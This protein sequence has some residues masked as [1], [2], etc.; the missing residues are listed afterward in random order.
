MSFISLTREFGTRFLLPS[1]VGV[2]TPA[3]C[4]FLK[5][6]YCS[7]IASSCQ[8]ISSFCIA[9]LSCSPS[10]GLKLYL[11]SDLIKKLYVRIIK[12]NSEE[13]QK[14]VRAVVSSEIGNLW[15]DEKGIT[16]E[17]GVQE[18]VS[19]CQNKGSC[20][21]AVVAFL[22][23]LCQVNAA[24]LADGELETR[25]KS[26]DCVRY[27]AMREIK[28]SLKN[29]I[30]LEPD[31]D[32][33][34][35]KRMYQYDPFYNFDAHKIFDRLAGRAAFS[36]LFFDIHEFFARY[37]KDVQN[38]FTGR[39]AY[40]DSKTNTGHSIAFQGNFG[41][42]R[43]RDLLLY[44]FSTQKALQDALYQKSL[45][46]LSEYDQVEIKLWALPAESY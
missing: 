7:Y 45:Q 11:E 6:A 37:E 39:I 25:I 14:E 33:S 43:Y 16:Y 10:I 22:H 19:V 34:F 17:Q 30:L 13:I 26:A 38:V 5:N 8:P 42:F 18:L 9:L 28:V 15:L 46:Y 2:F 36:K 29:R 21:G 40:F 4:I 12:Q 1:A 41:H 44:S 27:Q 23:L 20:D 24:K 35:L 31:D 32:E 3:F